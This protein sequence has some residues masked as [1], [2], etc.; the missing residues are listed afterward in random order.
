MTIEFVVEKQ[1]SLFN[2]TRVLETLRSKDPRLV[3][4][5][6]LFGSGCRFPFLLLFLFLVAL[7]RFL[8]LLFRFLFFALAFPGCFFCR[9]LRELSQA[10]TRTSQD[11]IGFLE[12]LGIFQHQVQ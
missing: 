6:F 12:I 7:G 11:R 3:R 1:E 5:G 4:L 10:V 9:G 2:A 8:F